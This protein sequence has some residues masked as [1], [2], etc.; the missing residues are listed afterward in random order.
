MTDPSN[1]NDRS[2]ISW[3]DRQR[4]SD[5]VP[6]Q[7]V[8]RSKKEPAADNANMP[9]TIGVTLVSL[10]KRVEALEKQDGG[11]DTGVAHPAAPSHGVWRG[12]DF[13]I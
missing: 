2:Q 5:G 8:T 10:M 11:K 12:E 9:D 3:T 4:S 13:T 6:G 7:I 1:A